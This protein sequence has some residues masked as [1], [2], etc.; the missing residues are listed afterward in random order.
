MDHVW[1]PVLGPLL[2]EGLGKGK[3]DKMV[4]GGL[5]DGGSDREGGT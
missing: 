5:D 3:G 4:S 2:W 1:E